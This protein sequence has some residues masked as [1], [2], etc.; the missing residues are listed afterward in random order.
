MTMT[1]DQKLVSRFYETIGNKIPGHLVDIKDGPLVRNFIF[2]PDEKAKMSTLSSILKDQKDVIAVRGKNITFQ[3][4]KEKRKLIYM[5]D[6]IKTK[7]F[8]NTK[9]VLPM[10]LGVDAVGKP[11]I[12]DLYKVPH[13]LVAAHTGSGK[14]IFIVGLIKSL[15]SKLSPTECKLVIFDP[16]MVDFARWNGEKHMLT[17]V[18]TEVEDGLKMF[19]YIMHMMEDRYQILRKNNVRNVMEYREK[20]KKKDM[21]HIVIV[22]DEFCDY[23]QVAKKKMEKFVET[24]CTKARATGIHLILGTQR[25][26]A[27][28]IS[29]TIKAF[30]PTRISFQARSMT[31]SVQMLGEHGAERLLPMADMLYSEAGRIPVRI[32]IAYVEC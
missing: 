12:E 7:E 31:D 30:I 29:K 11:K 5:K 21:P 23:M 13:L 15:I 17:D 28:T 27:E 20:T 19:E 22:M 10:I 24:I 16:R 18:V 8:I 32:H 2:E 3:I 4:P 14:S 9:A 1:A 25:P 6:L 26:D